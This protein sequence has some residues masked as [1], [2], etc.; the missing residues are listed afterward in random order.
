M[1]SLSCNVV[2]S[3]SIGALNC[4]SNTVHCDARAVSIEQYNRFQSRPKQCS[5]IPIHVVQSSAVKYCAVQCSVVQYK[6]LQC[7]VVLWL[8]GSF[9]WLISA[10]QGMYGF[11]ELCSQHSGQ[12]NDHAVLNKLYHIYHIK[13]CRPRVLLLVRKTSQHKETFWPPLNLVPKTL[14]QS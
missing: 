5:V 4:S 2:Q 7:S 14:C 9:P 6:A 12:S 13:M 10:L 3:T 8:K 11:S 1:L